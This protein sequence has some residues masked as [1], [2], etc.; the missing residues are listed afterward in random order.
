[1]K[2]IYVLWILIGA[3]FMIYFGYFL[4]HPIPILLIY[5]LVYKPLIDY[6]YIKKMK[7]YDGR[8]LIL[9]YPFWVYG[10]KL[11]FGE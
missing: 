6:F 5:I 9:K 10:R 2:R 8:C 11:L 3:V 1:M 4:N 7:L